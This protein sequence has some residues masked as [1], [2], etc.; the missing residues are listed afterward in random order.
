MPPSRE[1]SP[2]W[3]L[4]GPRGAG[5]STVGAALAGRL[6]VPFVD[7]DA[8][9]AQQAGEPVGALLTRVGEPQFRIREAACVAAALERV[10]STG[11]VVALGG[12]AVV[13]PEVRASLTGRGYRVIWLDVPAA[14]RCARIGRDDVARPALTDL[15]MP[16][17]V[18]LLD[19][20][21]NPLYDEVA[22]VRVAAREDSPALCVERIL[23]EYP[24]AGER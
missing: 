10:C 18:E 14:L 9:L 5:K 7:T 6:G 12:G 21:R 3:V 23:A 4:V 20:A 19:R 13:T 22:S 16:E 2:V 15:P 8:D 11:G 1:V 24:T 17:E